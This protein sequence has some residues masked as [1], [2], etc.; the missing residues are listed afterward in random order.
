MGR[1]RIA[2]IH[3][4]P[5]GTGREVPV[6]R[7]TVAVWNV[8]GRFYA[9]GPRCPHEDAPLSAG[10]LE[11]TVVTCPMHGWQF[12]VSTGQGVNPPHYRLRP[13]PVHV[14]GEDLYLDLGG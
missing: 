2:S 13:F 8:G 6:G 10:V 12:D 9:T 7:M 14:E 11:G 3:E 5:E 4:I 1:I